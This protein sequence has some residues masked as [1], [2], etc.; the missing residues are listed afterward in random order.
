MNAEAYVPDPSD[1][2]FLDRLFDVAV[3]LCEE[4]TSPDVDAWLDGREHLR[5]DVEALF[6]TARLITPLRSE[7]LPRVRGFT[8]LGEIGRGGMGAVYLARQETLGG[9]R[10]ALKVLPAATGLSARAR[11]R[12]LVE[13]RAIANLRHP[14]VVT[15]H[16]VVA[17]TDVLAYAMEWVDGGS[18]GQ[19]IEFLM[20]RR[21]DG[22]RG[23]SSSVGPSMSEVREFLG[24]EGP[25]DASQPILVC[26]VGIAVARALA[27]LHR[28][29]LVHRDVKPSNVLLRKDGT[30]LL[31]DF[32]LVHDSAGALTQS[33]QF[34]GTLDY[35]SPEQLGGDPG[36]LDARSDVY[37][38][39]V[40]LFHALTLH[41]PFDDLRGR[42]PRATTPTGMLRRMQSGRAV[43]LRAWNSRL[44]RDLETILS[45]A[46]DLDPSRRYSTADELGDELE[47]LLA[48][49]PIRARRAGWVSRSAKLLSR[50]RAAALG[51]ASGSIVSLALAVAVVVYI[52][53]V[54]HWVDQHV[55][56]ARLALL[57]PVQANAIF[58]SNFF[59]VTTAEASSRPRIAIESL[60][61]A[62]G[63]YDAALRWTPFDPAIRG[64]RAV[65]R[66]VTLAPTDG[67]AMDLHAPNDLRAAGLHAYLVGDVD[68]ALRHWEQFEQGREP[69]APPDPLVE[70]ALG[71]LFLVRE[72][73]ARAYP[74]LREACQAFPNVGFLTTY[75]ADAALGCGD[76]DFAE[77]LLNAAASMPR[78]DPIG[79]MERV[80]ADLLAARGRDAEA[81][82]IYRNALPATPTGLH[83]ARFL[84]SRGRVEESL[85][86]YVLASASLRG[87]QVQLEYVAAL[88]RWWER[89]SDE[90]R[91]QRIRMALDES[92]VEPR[93]L[94]ARLRLYAAVGL[95]IEPRPAEAHA[96]GPFT[97]F[98]HPSSLFAT[99]D[100][101]H[102]SP[103][104]RALISMPLATLWRSKTWSAGTRSRD[105]P[106][107]SS[108]CNSGLG[109]V[110]GRP[111]FRRSSST[112]P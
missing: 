15:V 8:L 6:R 5:A 68:L 39:G 83:Y 88:E 78:L 111:S 30:P 110:H 45:K 80:R 103:P 101:P 42:R 20:A 71:V 62:I 106:A 34:V 107:S 102:S 53:G 96:S 93:S 67:I 37:A 14:H 89:L 23:D 10:V 79:A 55:R 56:E 100:V 99:L 70:A 41:L 17:G 7:E 21:R 13:A 52:F 48:L 97:K 85:E 73:P 92:P 84:E 46:T 16:D 9:R 105:T 35:A 75:L 28:A 104:S 29:G 40:T 90:E 2:E 91:L 82:A 74:R 22:E 11:E 86:Q 36:S 108:T 98:P 26:R 24:E 19:L 112:S 94:V 59:G 4:G 51:I 44:P 69:I 25:A 87:R 109:R 32:G 61:D 12:F 81:E 27:A 58:N 31:S 18:L 49:Q 33:G 76:L 77:R 54:P 43:L 72:E 47:R 38:L 57:D 65:V 60:K 63:Q 1:E 95:S 3:S 64:E 66:A 50:N